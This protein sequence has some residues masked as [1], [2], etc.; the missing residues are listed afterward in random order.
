M[1]PVDGLSAGDATVWIL[2]AARLWPTCFLITA[3]VARQPRVLASVAISA[4]LAAS[5]W[6]LS[7]V[8]KGAAVSLSFSDGVR[9]LFVG[10]AFALAAATPVLGLVWVGAWFDRLREGRPAPLPCDAFARLYGALA[11]AALFA[12]GGHRLLLGAFV[13]TLREIPPFGPFD[14]PRAAALVRL[15]GGTFGRAL[16]WAV[17]W[18]APVFLGLLVLDLVLGGVRRFARGLPIEF[19]VAPVRTLGL[20]SLLA[21]ASVLSLQAYPTAIVWAARSA[22]NLFDI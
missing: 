21:A 5:L 17:T 18:A 16:G 6:P 9:E 3:V 7:S 1:N 12:F 22:S 4:L 14:V 8:P 10:M 2:V 13:D 15:V 20:L 19:V 11:L